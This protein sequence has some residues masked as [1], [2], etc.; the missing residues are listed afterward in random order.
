MGGGLILGRIV[1]MKTT[2]LTKTAPD[3]PGG[4]PSAA[5]AT[6]ARAVAAASADT[7]AA[8]TIGAPAAVFAGPVVAFVAI[9]VPEQPVL[10]SVSGHLQLPWLPVYSDC[11]TR[12]REAK[13]DL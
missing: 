10:G 5:K 4:L 13:I 12:Q 9:R 6:A 8:L 2:T 3:P 11:T 7:A 1:E